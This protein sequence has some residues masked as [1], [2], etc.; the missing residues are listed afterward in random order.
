MNLSTSSPQSLTNCVVW[1]N[2]DSS[3]TGTA[4][5]SILYGGGPLPVIEHSLIQGFN[6]QGQG[7]LDGT[8]SSNN[9]G[10]VSPTDPANAPKSG[11]DLR[12]LDGSPAIDAGDGVA[13]VSINDTDKDLSG[14]PRF[15]G[16]GTIDIGAY[17]GGS[18]VTFAW[19]HPTLLP[20]D[21]DNGNGVSNFGDYAAGGDPN[22]PDDA[23]LRPVINGDLLTFSFR[24]N[25]HDVIMGLEKSGNLAA[26]SWSNIVEDTDY[27]LESSIDDGKQT[28]FTIK[29]LADPLID[30]KMFYRQS[31]SP[32][33]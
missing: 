33:P 31:F 14:K 25:A 6:L 19:R 20:D 24:N 23:S 12:L 10:F 16:N 3:G 28:L 2:K 30:P 9:P 8:N 4:S 15:S 13:G 29:L 18:G 1:N 5:S 21:D 22:D 11:G 27:S 17:E 32:S 26:D 7:N